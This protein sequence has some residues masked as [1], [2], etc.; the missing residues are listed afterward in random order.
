M[1][2]FLSSG[3]RRLRSSGSSERRIDLNQVDAGIRQLAELIEIIAA[4]NDARI[5]ERRGFGCH[6]GTYPALTGRVNEEPWFYPNSN[7]S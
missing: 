3:P 1:S 5:N 6:T 4:I 7:V 2:A